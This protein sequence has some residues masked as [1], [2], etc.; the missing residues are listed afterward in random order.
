MS[1]KKLKIRI[2]KD[3]EVRDDSEAVSLDELILEDG[4]RRGREMVD[5][6][7]IEEMKEKK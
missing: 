6:L 5:K 2:P 3:S 4:R 7:F 1:D